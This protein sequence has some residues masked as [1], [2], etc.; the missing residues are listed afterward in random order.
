MSTSPAPSSASPSSEDE[1][2]TTIPE[3]AMLRP[4]DL[5]GANRLANAG[6]QDEFLRP[7]RPCG[8]GGA[9]DA[10]RLAA[11]RVHYAVTDE[12]L[13]GR[14]VPVAGLF[15]LV[16][17]FRPGGAQAY[18][19]EVLEE[20]G[21]CPTGEGDRRWGL[22]SS[23]DVLRLFVDRPVQYADTPGRQKVPVLVARTGDVVVVLADTGYETGDGDPALLSAVLD[24]ALARA[25]SAD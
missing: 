21:R 15:E 20:L 22:D 11:A 12:D 13:T 25:A 24:K 23:G 3:S 4:E 14:K 10:Q 18:Q 8:K 2:G 17:T 19:A 5:G 7:P 16:M 6:R 1:E 9:S